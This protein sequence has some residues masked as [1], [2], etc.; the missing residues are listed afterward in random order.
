MAVGLLPPPLLQRSFSRK[1]L[2]LSTVCDG[3]LSAR[4][5]LPSDGESLL[6]ISPVGAGATLVC[7]SG[8]PAISAAADFGSFFL[9]G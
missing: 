6:A 7:S 8:V 4:S 9:A 5:L 2:I 1:A 3:S